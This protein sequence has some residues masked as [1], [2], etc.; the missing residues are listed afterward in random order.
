MPV[1][2]EAPSGKVQRSRVVC[3]LLTLLLLGGAGL[4]YH[5]CGAGLLPAVWTWAAAALA[6]CLPGSALCTLLCRQAPADLRPTLCLVYGGAGFALTTVLASFTGLHVLVWV[7][8]AAGCGLWLVQRRKGLHP[9]DGRQKLPGLLPVLCAVF[10]FC[11]ALWAVRY[12][13]PSVAT[14]A[15]PSQD[16][17]WNLGN[18]QS[19]LAGFPMA[20]LRVEGVTVSY[21]FLTELFG[22]GL[23][24]LTGLPAYDVVAFY[25]YAP[26]AAAM[27]VCL[28]G[29]GRTLWGETAR[30]RPL[31]LA[32][33]PLWLGCASLWKV[34]DTG[35]G[36]FGN[37][38]EI[39]VI[40]NIN[41]QA[42]ALFAL[43]AFFAVFAR[44]EQCRW[45]APAGLWA[46]GVLAFYLLV[47]S[48]SPQGAILALALTCALGLRGLFAL[49]TRQKPG[50]ALVCFCLLVPVGFWLVYQLYF[51]AGADSSMAFSLTGTLNLYF[52]ASI[53]QALQIRLG[54][55]WP[56]CLPVLWLA[57][58]L[59]AAPAAFCVWVG[60]ALRDLF[61]LRRVSALHLTWHACIVGGLAAFYWF[62]HYSSSQL[63]FL[64]LAIFCLGLVLLDRLP[65]LWQ[66]GKVWYRQA[67]RAGCAVLLAV[68]C[69]TSLFTAV[70]LVRTAPV[71]LAGGTPDARYYALTAEEEDAARWLAEN[72]EPDALFATNRMH[73]GTAQEGLSNVYSGLSG[74]QAY[75][76]S[77]K[78]AV[79]NMG[80][81][82]GDVMARYE[83]VSRMF[84]P[85]ISEAE[86]RQ[87]CRETGV[88]YL[89]YHAPSPGS[90]AQLACLEQVYRSDV[91]SIYKVA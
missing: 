48:K 86:L 59:L 83:T 54:G 79:S 26:V 16:F 2:L 45:Q 32:S 5:R 88:T 21:H 66:G 20:D 60:S 24:M 91:I 73:T 65:A 52:F 53:L 77:F 14:V 90:D 74:R 19:L 81:R 58:S 7:W 40:S 42:T 29:L 3:G 47:F 6:V 8:T 17:F 62:D 75:C 85:E 18:T 11:N 36:R 76:E 38:L 13:H 69:V 68:G 9:G 46:A 30:A 43:A 57:Q 63:Y 39:Y 80:D 35:L 44:L 64:I 10:V 50:R 28:Y 87:L 12:L 25:G 34:L 27:V 84:S 22:A 56:V 82:A 67:A 1:I 61:H 78:Y 72:M 4:L 89:V 70:W 37:V 33:L 15:R 49:R 31:L 23:C 55:L 51:A 71:Q 41:G